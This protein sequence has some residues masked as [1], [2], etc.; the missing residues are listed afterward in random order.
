MRIT[1]TQTEKK[2]LMDVVMGRDVPTVLIRGGQILN[3]YTGRVEQKDLVL[4]GRWIAYVGDYTKSGCIFNENTKII[5]LDGQVV[6]PGYIEPHAHPFQLY[7]PLSLAEKVCAHGTTT[8]INDNLVFFSQLEVNEF[9]ALIEEIDKR[10]P[11]KQF[12]WAR[13]DAQTHLS[14][15]QKHLFAKERVQPLIDHEL[16]LQSG[17]LTDW[18]PLLLEDE[19]MHGWMSQ[20]EQNRKRIEG[21]A[22]GASFLTL[23]RLA[24][25]GVTGDHE[26]ISFKEVWQRL[27]LG[28]MVTLRHSSIRP[29]LPVLMEQLSKEKDVPWHRLMMTTD[30]ATPPY[31]KKGFSDY[32][33]RTAIQHGCPPIQA[34]QMVTLFPAIY[35]QL[36]SQL[37]GIAPGKLADF[38][39]LSSLDEPTPLQV[40]VEG[41]RLAENQKVLHSFFEMDWKSYSKLKWKMNVKIKPTALQIPQKERQSFPVMNLQNPVITKMTIEELPL[42]DG[43]VHWDDDDDRCYTFLIDRKGKWMTPGV[44]RGFGKGIDGIASSY[45]SSND[46]LLIGRDVHAMAQAANQVIK[47]KGGVVW[48][49]NNQ[50]IHQI[51]LPIAGSM[52]PHSVDQLIAELDPLIEN[53]HQFGHPFDDPIYTFLFLSSTHLPQLRLTSDG[54][55]RVKDKKVLVSSYPLP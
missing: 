24:A 6:V 16:V 30:G 51:Q 26:S 3:V 44:I 12:W 2:Y 25:A 52:S 50:I 1:C 55:M 32:L 15:K 11:V 53:L 9:I 21:H 49:Q 37:G 8:L 54:L 14:T 22:P 23:S 36:D 20:T 4:A 40:Y 33:I 47:Q 39:I 29:D 10:S 43:N 48:V 13:L 45:T 34:Y 42:V 17:E 31:L 38:N 7:H 27:E 41:E 35:Y 19:K 46:L 5:D 28:Y 18:M